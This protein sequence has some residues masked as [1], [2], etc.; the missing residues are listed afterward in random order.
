VTSINDNVLLITKY[1]T[2][3][4]IRNTNAPIKEDKNIKTRVVLVF[5]DI[6]QQKRAE[7]EKE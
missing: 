2:K 4:P 5:Q 3:I 7:K 6:T 1:D